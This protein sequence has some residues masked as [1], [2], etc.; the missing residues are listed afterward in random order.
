[1]LF[2]LNNYCQYLIASN[3]KA[4]NSRS[5]YCLWRSHFSLWRYC[6][7]WLCFHYPYR[8]VHCGLAQKYRHLGKAD[9]HTG[10]SAKWAWAHNRKFMP[11]LFWLGVDRWYLIWHRADRWKDDTTAYFWIDL[12][13]GGSLAAHGIWWFGAGIQKAKPG[14]VVS[15]SVCHAGCCLWIKGHGSPVAAQL[16]NSISNLSNRSFWFHLHMDPPPFCY[17]KWLEIPPR[18]REKKTFPGFA[19]IRFSTKTEKVIGSPR[20]QFYFWFLQLF[21]VGPIRMAE[22]YTSPRLMG[23]EVLVG[24]KNV[25]K[26]LFPQLTSS[27]ALL[28]MVRYI[29]SSTKIGVSLSFIIQRICMCMQ[30]WKGL[31]FLVC[32]CALTSCE[33]PCLC[34]VTHSAPPAV[35]GG[36]NPTASVV[37]QPCWPGAA[38]PGHTTNV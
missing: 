1:M 27:G 23:K 20:Y 5:H 3:G 34:R 33:P 22:L 28:Q 12:K 18:V 2:Q 38:G 37:P 36:T 35:Q 16:Q 15:V 6:S 32:A 26:K 14:S 11:G 7:I 21:L 25:W 30:T 13:W 24:S 9:A 29:H 4:L 17:W 19:S 10:V 31:M 8:F